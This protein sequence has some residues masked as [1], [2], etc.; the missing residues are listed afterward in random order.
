VIVAR[1]S[2][3]LARHDGT[4]LSPNYD[5]SPNEVLSTLAAEQ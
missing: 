2:R 5:N 3:S 4:T 1:S